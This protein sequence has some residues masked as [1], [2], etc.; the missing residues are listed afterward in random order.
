MS[1]RP[2]I[3]N[4]ATKDL[5][6]SCQFPAWFLTGSIPT[7]PEFLLR[8]AGVGMFVVRQELERGETAAGCAGASW[9]ASRE[10]HSDCLSVQ[11]SMLQSAE[12][13]VVTQAKSTL[14]NQFLASSAILRSSG[15]KVAS[16]LFRVEWCRCETQHSYINLH[17]M[18]WVLAWSCQTPGPLEPRCRSIDKHRGAK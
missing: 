6:A 11:G 18:A 5:A 17:G 12:A 15:K 8:E 1:P 2:S 14:Q 4:R 10:R 9:P 7:K 13:A 16:K 3:F